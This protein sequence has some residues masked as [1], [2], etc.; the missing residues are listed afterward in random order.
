MRY[1]NVGEAHD[2]L[3]IV[4]HGDARCG[5]GVE[6]GERLAGG[7]SETQSGAESRRPTATGGCGH[8]GILGAQACPL[9]RLVSALDILAENRDYR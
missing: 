2:A 8:Y 1:L 3:E 7:R 5:P 4:E 9:Q 6:A